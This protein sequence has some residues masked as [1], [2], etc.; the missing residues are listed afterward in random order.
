VRLPEPPYDPGER[1]AEVEGC[2]LDVG[3]VE[4]HI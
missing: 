1:Q 4:H 2:P 3:L